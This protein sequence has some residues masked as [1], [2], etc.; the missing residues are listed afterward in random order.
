MQIPLSLGRGMGGSCAPFTCNL[1]HQPRFTL[2]QVYSQD[3]FSK[4]ILIKELTFYRY[5]L[6]EPNILANGIFNISLSTTTAPVNGLRVR[7]ETS[8]R[9]AEFSEHEAD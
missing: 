4:P 3:V 5:P 2:Q 8:G 9:I 6:A 7:P 1:D